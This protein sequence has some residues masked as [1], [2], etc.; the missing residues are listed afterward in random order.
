MFKFRKLS[1]ALALTASAVLLGTSLPA[2]AATGEDGFTI[3]YAGYGDDAHQC[4]VVGSVNGSAG[5]YQAVVCADII[6]SEVTPTDYYAYG[7]VWAYCQ[8]GSGSSAV[9]V[10]CAGV[11][12]GGALYDD[13]DGYVAGVGWWACGHQYGAC[14]AGRNL[15][16]T[17]PEQ[18]AYTSNT[19]CGQDPTSDHD[20]WMNVL[21]GAEIEIPYYD[22]TVQL[23][24][25][26]GANDG[27]NFSTGH[28]YVC[29]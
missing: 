12:F 27:S 25:G 11:D 24:S 14:S 10:Q 4:G 20:V 18:I 21:Q 9:N 23:V 2:S 15:L 7:Q 5:L 26:S 17:Y 16:S 19:D 1:L 29:A 28:Y 8:E 6:T 3:L 22:D 13:A